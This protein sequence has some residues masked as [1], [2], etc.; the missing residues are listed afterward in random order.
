[1]TDNRAVVPD[2]VDFHCLMRE[3]VAEVM[4]ATLVTQLVLRERLTQV[5]VL[6]LLVSGL[7]T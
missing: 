6:S 7:L 3:L 1:M 5:N 4:A 2:V